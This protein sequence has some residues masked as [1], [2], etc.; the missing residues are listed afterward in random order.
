MIDEP[1]VSLRPK[2][3]RKILSY[4]KSLFSLRG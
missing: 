1:E 4:Y 3:V 2:W